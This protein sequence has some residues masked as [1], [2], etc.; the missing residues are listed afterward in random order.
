M[1]FKKINPL[2]WTSK[3]NEWVDTKHWTLQIVIL[4][5]VVFCVRTFLFGLYW[6]PTGS[7][8]PTILVGESFFAEDRIGACDLINDVTRQVMIWLDN[9]VFGD[10]QQQ[11]QQQRQQNQNRKKQQQKNLIVQTTDAMTS[12]ATATTMAVTATPT[13]ATASSTTATTMIATTPTPKKRK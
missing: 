2:Y 7:M 6:V 1:N 8:E 11:K 13:E 5:G 9:K 3:F 4:L 10:Q 12:T